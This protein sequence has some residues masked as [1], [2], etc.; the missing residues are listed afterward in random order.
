MH[1]FYVITDAHLGGLTTAAHRHST[2]SAPEDGYIVFEGEYSSVVPREA[3][4]KVHKLG[5]ATLAS[6]V[7]RPPA[8]PL[9]K[10]CS[11]DL[12]T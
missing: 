3:H 1:D 8:H 4:E 6:K 5:Q 12:I 10:A 11:S 2:D 7:S 9:L